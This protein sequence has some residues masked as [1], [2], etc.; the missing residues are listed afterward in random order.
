MKQK[1]VPEVLAGALGTA[2][3]RIRE[4]E[5]ALKAAK[6][7]SAHSVKEL[8]KKARESALEEAAQVCDHKAQEYERKL[9]NWIGDHF[10]VWHFYKVSMNQCRRNATNIRALMLEG[11]VEALN[12]THAPTVET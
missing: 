2:Q 4:L 6:D 11:D 1:E 3:A 7:L 5:D 10:L 9:K 8:E 12:T